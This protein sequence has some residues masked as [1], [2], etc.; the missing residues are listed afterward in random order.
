MASARTF[1]LST[2]LS[3]FIGTFSS[4]LISSASFSLSSPTWINSS[5]LETTILLSLL[6]AL[7]LSSSLLCSFL[8]FDSFL[9]SSW[10]FFKPVLALDDVFFKKSIIDKPVNIIIPHTNNATLI[11]KVPF[12]ST[13]F[14]NINEKP[15]PIIPPPSAS[16]T[17]LVAARKLFT[18]WFIISI[19]F[20]SVSLI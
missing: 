16:A 4:C 2:C 11:I 9:I 20:K 14:K 7:F 17:T 19:S 10:T 8:F 3:V 5:T 18:V 1:G 12:K 15:A 6:F 13:N